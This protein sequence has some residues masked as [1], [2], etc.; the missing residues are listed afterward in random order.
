MGSAASVLS[1]HFA[2][3]LTADNTNI[4]KFYQIRIIDLVFIISHVG[5]RVEYILYVS[6]ISKVEFCVAFWEID[7]LIINCWFVDFKEFVT[8]FE[9]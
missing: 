9:Y 3:Y 2:F 7:V 1:Y 6:L 4:K 8:P 5:I